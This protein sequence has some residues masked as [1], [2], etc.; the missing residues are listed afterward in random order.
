MPPLAAHVTV[1]ATRQPGPVT[2]IPSRRYVGRVPVP[3]NQVAAALREHLPGVAGPKLHRLLYYI[4][5]HH[6][7]LFGR[8]AFD[9]PILA[10]PDGPHL[11]GL[12][13]LDRPGRPLPES[14]ANV[15]LM[16][17]TRYGGLTA[18]DLDRLTRS[19]PPWQATTPNAEI[20]PERL[21]GFFAGPGAQEHADQYPPHV[22]SRL[23]EGVRRARAAARN[24]PPT[25]PLTAAELIAKV[26]GRDRR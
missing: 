20:T 22:V 12:T 21:R 7:A 11:A 26:A 4:Q 8:P 24:Q 5:G 13:G 18:A 17:A 6:L 23:R 9:Q 2:T 3:A 1:R 16:V 19:E 14:Q 15:A 10:G 25:P